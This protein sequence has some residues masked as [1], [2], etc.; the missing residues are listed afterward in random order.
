MALPA[1]RLGLSNHYLFITLREHL[2]KVNCKTQNILECKDDM[3]YVWNPEESC[4]LT[5]NLKLCRDEEPDRPLMHQT[6]QPTDPPIHEVELLRSN[7][8]ATQLALVGPHGISVL[9]LPRRW[10]RGGGFLGGKPSVTCRCRGVDQRHWLCNQHV[11]VRAAQWHPGSDADSLLVVLASNNTIRVYDTLEGEP[12][13]HNVWVVGRMP[14][15]SL[16]FLAALGD[17]AV[18]FT[19]TPPEET[20]SQITGG[21]NTSPSLQWPILVLYGNGDV[22]YVVTSVDSES[23]KKPLLQGPISMF[24]PADDNYGVDSCSILCLQCVPPVVVIASCSGTL[25]H[26]F[27]LNNDAESDNEDDKSLVSQESS[28]YTIHPADVSLHVFEAVELELGLALND[29][30][31][32]YTCPIYLHADCISASR[33]FCSHDTGVHVVF[34]PTVSQLDQFLDCDDDKLHLCTSI[35]SQNAVVEYAVCTRAAASSSETGIPQEGSVLPVLG[36]VQTPGT[37]VMLVALLAS[38]EVISLTLASIPLPLPLES[39]DRL[40]STKEK[41]ESPLKAMLKEPFNMRITN[42]LK[43]DVTQPILKLGPQA[44]T[45]PQKYM[46]L[47]NQSTQLLREEYFLKHDQVREEIDK[48]ARTLRLMKERQLKELENLEQEKTQLKQAAEQLAEKYEDT[49]DKQEEL[50]KRAEKIL[51][52]V[53]RCQPLV[54]A[55][56]KKL[57]RQLKEVEEKLK[58]YKR[59]MKQV[60]AKEAYHKEQVLQWQA[61][62]KEKEIQLGPGRINNLKVT[63]K[64]MEDSIGE[65]VKTINFIKKEL[66]T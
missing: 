24:P 21:C 61:Q 38:G 6:L 33:Y 31:D 62:L 54:S 22:Y 1:D 3:L 11:E 41:T 17:T 49:K 46:E 29:S 60:K 12:A 36:L 8:T 4:V 53:V 30:T 13:L 34:I 20:T 25:Y 2:K 44:N 40:E 66:N 57:E 52:Q 16:P 14:A 39:A 59:A 35:L 64:Q 10:G 5:L 43:H 37:P 28:A 23:F 15:S 7:Q 50:S 32:T 48:R 45:T 18:D 19:F 56:E 63:L 9:E 42:M 51:R 58:V 27:L 55:A 47:V 65:L 26:C